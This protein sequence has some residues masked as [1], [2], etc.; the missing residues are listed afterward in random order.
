MYISII[1]LVLFNLAPIPILIGLLTI[2]KARFAIK[3]A[4]THLRDKGLI[5]AMA[6]TILVHFVTDILIFLGFFITPFIRIIL[7]I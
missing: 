3:T 6:T 1:L 4:K 7:P 2:P 5:N